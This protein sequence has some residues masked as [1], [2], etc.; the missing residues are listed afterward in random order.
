MN[1]EETIERF[2]P[3]VT[4]AIRRAEA[5]E[6]LEAPGTAAAY[7]DVS[8]LEEKIADSLPPSDPEGALAR[9]GAVR[10]AITAN[11]PQRAQQLVERF[12][13]EDGV[14]PE[15]HDEL[16]QFS[17]Q[18]EEAEETW[19]PNV[20]PN[21]E[22]HAGAVVVRGPRKSLGRPGNVAEGDKGLARRILALERSH[23]R[24]EKQIQALIEDLRKNF[25]V[26]AQRNR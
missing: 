16:L 22:G 18:A 23:K 14:E 4:E 15:L 17:R 3:L 10:A 20:A 6:D 11:K 21:A 1:K 7:L 24:L 9:R 25:A 2:Y 12:L 19:L 26:K 5:L 13:A 8:L